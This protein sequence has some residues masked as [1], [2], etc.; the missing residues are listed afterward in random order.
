MSLKLAAGIR[1]RGL[2]NSGLGSPIGSPGALLG[3]PG[4][5]LRS[6]GALLG[7]PGE[8]KS[9]ASRRSLFHSFRRMSAALVL[10]FFYSSV[11]DL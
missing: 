10:F 6:P 9:E 4:A 7:P 11:A 2:D 8:T 1:P 3:S 5:L